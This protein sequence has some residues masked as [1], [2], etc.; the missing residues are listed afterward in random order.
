MSPMSITVRHVLTTLAALLPALAGA[1]AG[2]LDAAHRSWLQLNVTRATYAS[3]TTGYAFGGGTGQNVDQERDLAL[4]DRRPYGGLLM[5]RRIGERFRIEVELTRSQRSGVALLP[6]DVTLDGVTWVGGSALRTDF[7]FRTTRVSGGFSA[8]V[9]PE[10]EFGVAFGGHVVGVRRTFEGTS[11][12]GARYTAESDATVQPLLG[13]YASFDLAR[14]LRLA[15]RVDSSIDDDDYLQIDLSATLR[16][17]PNVGIG[18]GWRF[19]DARFTNETLFFGYDDFGL[20][21]Y[22]ARGPKLLFEAS[23]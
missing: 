18:I 13:L 21:R 19:V 11:T 17:A 4:D 12:G 15:G 3:S 22:R 10:A 7:A 2:P 14:V 9:L 8:V 16:P 1:Q 20:L 23:F 5:G 6:A